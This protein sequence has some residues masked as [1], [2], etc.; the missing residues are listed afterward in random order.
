MSK[1]CP[2]CGAELEDNAIFCDECGG[3]LEQQ[4][5]P[6]PDSPSTSPVMRTNISDASA[7][8]LQSMVTSKASDGIKNSGLGIA[9]MVLG[10]ISVC[11]LG[12]LFIPEIVGLILGIIAMGKK[13]TK[14]TFAVVGIVTSGIAFVLVVVIMLMP[15]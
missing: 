3:R 5:K 9:S 10:I 15:V 11:F 12:I 1:K 8:N 4:R 13:D 7:I 2:N 6:N 14:H